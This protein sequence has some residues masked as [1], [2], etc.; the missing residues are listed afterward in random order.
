M[1]Y[2]R[3][4]VYQPKTRVDL[5]SVETLPFAFDNLFAKELNNV[6]VYDEHLI[7]GIP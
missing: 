3:I 5:N 6:E 4:L 2:G 1:V 7:P